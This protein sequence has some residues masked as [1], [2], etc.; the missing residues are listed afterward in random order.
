MHQHDARADTAIAGRPTV[1][2]LGPVVHPAMLHANVILI[3]L[4]GSGK[5][6]IGRLLAR[7]LRTS[8]VDLD[9]RTPAVLGATSVA[10]AWA[11]HGEPAFRHAET[12][13]LAA[14]LSEPPGVLALGGGT[15]TAPGAADLLR[16]ASERGATVIYLRGTPASLAARLARSHNA[17]RPSL[18]GHAANSIEE[19]TKVF[20]A[21]DPLYRTIATD[22]LEID[23]LKL[24]QAVAAVERTLRR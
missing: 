15:P 20:E 1:P 24:T 9:D 21:R 11:A 5:T 4:R 12:T 16:T 13:A 7:G 18:T 8:F 19:I 10:D 3:G 14:V 17:H 23:G 22:T 6:T 2:Q